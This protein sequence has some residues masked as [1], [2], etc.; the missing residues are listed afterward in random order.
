MASITTCAS[1][2]KITFG[3]QLFFSQLRASLT[4]KASTIF[5]STTPLNLRTLA[6]TIHPSA[7]LA[8]QLTLIL[9]PSSNGAASV[10]SLTQPAPG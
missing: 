6:A 4:P 7:S 8:I 2:S 3:N 9:F 1:A 10:F 5:G